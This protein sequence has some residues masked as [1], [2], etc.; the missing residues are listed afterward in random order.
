MCVCAQILSIVLLIDKLQLKISK[1]E[2]P[3]AYDVSNTAG[4]TV[5]TYEHTWLLYQESWGL[6]TV[7]CPH[8]LIFWWLTSASEPRAM[9]YGHIF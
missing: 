8:I 9:Q 2:N 6:S 3:P 7:P 5:H 4:Y 1:K